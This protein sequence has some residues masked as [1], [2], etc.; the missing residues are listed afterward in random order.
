MDTRE[1]NWGREHGWIVENNGKP[2]AVLSNCRKESYPWDRYTVSSASGGV[3]PPVIC[4]LDFWT[5]ARAFRN[6][7]TGRVVTGV[8]V[9]EHGVPSR[10][11]D[12]IVVRFLYH[13]DD[14]ALWE[15]LR[16]VILRWI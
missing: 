13:R 7:G 15:R 14:P 4:K 3:I 9:S 1:G 10:D 11:D 5:A 12:T 6:R 16:S 2:I 8:L